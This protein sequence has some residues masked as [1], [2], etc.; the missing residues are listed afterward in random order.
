MSS[1]LTA[2][3]VR[4]PL[5][6]PRAQAVTGV[7]AGTARHLGISV[8]LVRAI[9]VLATMLS[10]AGA[11][12][13]LWLWVFLPVDPAV[14][15]QAGDDPR[16]Q[17]ITRRVPMAWLLLS[18]SAVLA[19]TSVGTA[20]R[21]GS[22]VWFS[23][24]LGAQTLAVAAALWA[25][26]LD[27]DDIDR[28]PRHVRFV[29]WSAVTL[30]VLL[31]IASVV[32]MRVTTDPTL[33]LIAGMTAVLALGGVFAPVII[34]RFRELSAERDQ[35]IREEQRSEMAAHLHDSVLQTLALIQNRAGS[36]S[37][38][39]RIAR[40]QE[41]E[42]RGWLYDADTPADSDLA[43][44]LRDYAAALE[45]DYAVHIDVVAAGEATERASGEVA[46]AAREAMLNA[47]RHAGGDVST[48][49]ES[50][51]DQV[52]VFIRDRGPGF[53]LDEVPDDRLGVRQSIIG[54]MRRIG[55]TAQVRA[56]AGGIGTEVRLRLTTRPGP[57]EETRS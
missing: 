54:R 46:A 43:T 29:R 14:P 25:G 56:G 18:A 20:D 34:T 7:A 9:F 13:Y 28:G 22:P 51:P 32:W 4:P 21:A 40:A 57:D 52:E 8:T 50:R 23:L 55:G 26:L 44:D 42:L 10:G 12:L 38:V 31:L 33:T 2:P 41:R 11:M 5:R 45:L 37:E 35:R 16:E 39:A 17:R 3:L 53:A 15:A 36:S 24:A 6:R 30:I 49:I 1:P 47:A 27:G 19:L 48:Y